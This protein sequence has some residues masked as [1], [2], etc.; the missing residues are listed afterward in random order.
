MPVVLGG[1]PLGNCRHLVFAEP[2][3][4]TREL[5]ARTPAVIE[6]LPLLPQEG[7]VEAL[8]DF[9]GLEGLEV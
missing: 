9:R 6:L 1:S 8:L 3:R 7:L 4:G 5:T 2:P